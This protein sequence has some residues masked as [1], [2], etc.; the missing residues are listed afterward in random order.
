MGLIYGKKFHIDDWVR[1]WE[2]IAVQKPMQRINNK[3]NTF[4]ASHEIMNVKT[5]L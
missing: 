2:I 4:H 1:A 3:K 5:E